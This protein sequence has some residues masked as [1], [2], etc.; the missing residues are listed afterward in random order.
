MGFEDWHVGF[1]GLEQHAEVRTGLFEDL[2]SYKFGYL[3][4]NAT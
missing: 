3:G 1:W 2:A 4:V